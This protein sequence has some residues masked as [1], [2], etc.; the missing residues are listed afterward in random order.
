MLGGVGDLAYYGRDNRVV[1]RHGNALPVFG[2]Y[3]ETGAKLIESDA[4]L[5]ELGGYDI[6]PS[7]EVEPTLLATPAPPGDHGAEE[8]RMLFFIAEGRGEV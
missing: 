6:P 2:T 4:P 5:A 3:G 7:I 1:D 8:I